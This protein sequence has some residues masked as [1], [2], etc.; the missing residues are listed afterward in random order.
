VVATTS[1]EL[2]AE[3]RGITPEILVSFSRGKDSIAT[4]LRV[5]E[6]FE[7]VVPYTYEV[8]PGLEFVEESLAYYEKLMG[9]RIIR[10]PSPG[11]PRLLNN[12]VFQPPDR[13][14]RIEYLRMPEW[15]HDDLQLAAC[16]D[17]GLDY[18]TAYNAVGVR[19]KDSAMRALIIKKHGPVNHVRRIFYPIF[20][21][22]KE[23]VIDCIKRAGWKLP[24][25]YRYF[26]S[27]F[28]GLYL[29][30]ALPIK[31]FFPRDWQR[32]CD[33]FPLLELEV[34]RYE[35]AVKRGEQPPYIPPDLTA[36]E[37]ALS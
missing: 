4:Y 22:S 31:R 28:D 20:D 3:I 8:V 32:L 25:D 12:L 37:G 24:I 16:D 19:A 33:Y 29:K 10:L 30:F 7:N 21:W 11:F 1:Q 5:R 23:E 27:S 34:L 9:R 6:K 26:S 15:S 13:I 35:S 36:Y 2:I 17:A 18:D 14:E